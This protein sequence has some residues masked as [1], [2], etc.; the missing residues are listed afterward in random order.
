MRIRL[1]LLA[2][3]IASPALAADEPMATA[4]PSVAE[5]AGAASP[6]R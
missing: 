1:A 3:L 4:S 5:K 2:A 6:I